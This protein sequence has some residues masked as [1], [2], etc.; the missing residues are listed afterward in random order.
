MRSKN[1]FILSLLSIS[2]KCIAQFQQNI[3][4]VKPL[5]P[6]VTAM[7]KVLERP[8]GS[9][10][11]TVPVNFPLLS[12]SSGPLQ[13]GLSLSYSGTGG[14]RV[15][16][17]ASCVGLGFSL[18]DGAGRI[19][20]T[21]N[22]LPDD[23][24]FGILDS[25]RDLSTFSCSSMENLWLSTVPYQ[26]DIEPD[27][28]MY[29]FNGRSGKFFFK[30]NGAIVI[31]ENAGIKIEYDTANIGS[32]GIHQ[33]I[34]TDEKGNKYYFG[35]NKSKTISYTANSTYEYQTV[36]D[37]GNSQPGVS[38]HSWYLTEVYD[39]N[40]ENS[41]K[42]TYVSQNDVT[43]TFS[44][45]FYK[46]WTFGSC[47]GFNVAPGE[48]TVVTTTNEYMVSKI[49][50]G[51]SGY[52][53]VNSA[54]DRTD[55]TYLRKVNNIELYD[56]TGVFKK[57]V[58]FNYGYFNAGEGDAYMRRLKLISFSEFGSST[59][60][61][62]SHKFTYNE[63]TNLPSRL[64]NSVD[65]WGYY[66]GK[67]NTSHFPNLYYKYGSYIIRAVKDAD[68][69]A[70]PVYAQADILT[71]ITYP[72]G[73][74]RQFIYEGNQALM[75]TLNEHFMDANFTA[76][77]SFT[78]TSF[79][80]Y[81]NPIPA[82]R[83]NF[84]VNSTDGGANFSYSLSPG[85]CGTYTIKIFQVT[86]PTDSLGGT[87]LYT[88]NNVSSFSYDLLNGYYRLE[89]YKTSSTC[90][91]SSITGS[92][93]ESTLS[94]ATITTPVGTFNRNNI[95]AGGVRVKQI[96]D[97]DPVTNKSSTTEYRYKLYSTDSTFTSGVLI[98]P[99][100]MVTYENPGS[101]DGQFLAVHTTSCYPL[102]NEGGS[103]VVYPEVRTIQYGNGWSDRKYSFMADVNY[104]YYPAVPP[105][106]YSYARGNLQTEK[107]YD[108]SGT[109][110]RKV[111]YGYVYGNGSGSQIGF[112]HKPYYNDAQDNGGQDREHPRDENEWPTHADCHSYF[113]SV[114]STLPSST[115]DSVFSPT[116][117]LSTQTLYS[118]YNYNSQLILSKVRTTINNGAA[119][120]VSC[121]YPF[122]ANA[123][124]SLF[125]NAAEQSMKT[126][127]LTRNC[128]T[129]LEVIDSLKP[130]SGTASF[131]SATK[132]IFASFN[133][134]DYHLSQMRT[135]TTPTDSVVSRFTNYD[136]KGN[137]REQ[138]RVNDIK[139]VYIWGYRG[140]YPVAK[141]TNS[142][143]LA[144]STL[145]AGAN[146]WA[147][148]SDAT[149]RSQLNNLRTGLAGS[150][151]MV[152]TYT[153][154]PLI[155]ITSETDPSGKTVYYEYDALG[156][157]ILIRDQNNNIV[158]KIE[159]KLAG[160]L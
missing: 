61:S 32:T 150:K 100:H 127:L 20:Q 34:I 144:D 46:S 55:A 30:E 142:N 53:L 159:Y 77:Q 13:T 141:I 33:F 124:F 22:S 41:L 154:L 52:L 42:Y 138:D 109:L 105:A 37:P 135:Y 68:R 140:Q 14:I 133:S 119:R 153:Y 128:L 129:P 85:T 1:L 2:T 45:G 56:S 160:A 76:S 136:L 72:T 145:I 43:T 146:L 157:L 90:N 98:S 82:L 137:L 121:K 131:V 19:V 116:A 29:N 11:G 112:R 67:F 16:E 15:E 148:A 70:V 69:S 111:S 126:N 108:V 50:G 89:L 36:G 122:T 147:P 125:L 130:A 64:S 25:R 101:W 107:F 134:G 3:P 80:S 58:K 102:A 94:T 139:E 123:S 75:S 114:T 84:T 8:T 118:Y 93:K 104:N 71:K 110:L 63:T 81:T 117:T 54:A 78:K 39:M 4:Q 12:L 35:Q 26:Y 18:A 143:Y 87:V 97:Y 28:F 27:V 48:A 9:F 95:N 38:N 31:A 10:T 156:R 106:D 40:E 60:D 152:S 151:A 73:G 62:I 74:Y 99:V 65:L 23:F 96:I 24:G 21:I 91:F 88:Q 132:Y 49:D 44:G 5:S 57:R 92:W 17:I 59:T 120:E 83:Q 47:T 6:D 158:K 155:G 149:L 51:S 86:T 103:Y 66:N 7:F 113:A 79:T 115:L